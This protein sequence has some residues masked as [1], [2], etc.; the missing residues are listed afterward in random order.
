MVAWFTLLSTISSWSENPIKKIREKMKFNWSI[1]EGLDFVFFL[2]AIP[3][4]IIVIGL[5]LYS[6]WGILK[7]FWGANKGQRSLSDKPFWI[8]VSI[9]LLV[10]FMLL[11]GLFW[12]GLELIY[13]WTA[14]QKI[15]NG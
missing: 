3:Y 5:L 1:F 12:D 9:T 15:T 4:T 11:S 13:S 14:N 2:L 8:R 7:F 6:L 10:L